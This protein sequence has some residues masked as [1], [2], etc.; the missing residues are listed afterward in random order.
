[1]KVRLVLTLKE[2]TSK[3]PQVVLPSPHEESRKA[4]LKDLAVVPPINT[5]QA[6]ELSTGLEVRIQV[7]LRMNISS[8]NSLKSHPHFSQ[9][10]LKRHFRQRTNSR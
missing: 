1:M 10:M 9:M 2:E 5:T 7:P 6:V 3:S 8:N 4:L